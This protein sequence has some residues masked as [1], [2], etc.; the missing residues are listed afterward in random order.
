M[1]GVAPYLPD[2]MDSHAFNALCGMANEHEMAQQAKVTE[3]NQVEAQQTNQA[4]P[5][6]LSVDS[7][8]NAPVASGHSAARQSFD[9]SRSFNRRGIGEDGVRRTN[10]ARDID[11]N[12]NASSIQEDEKAA[13][14]TRRMDTYRSNSDDT[15]MDEDEEEDYLVMDANDNDN[16]GDASDS[17]AGSSTPKDAGTRYELR[18]ENSRHSPNRFTPSDWSTK[19]LKKGVSRLYKNVNDRVKKKYMLTSC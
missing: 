17:A 5:S 14:Y 6:C 2:H 3:E 9:S 19:G 10:T 13:R 1:Q 18:I 12:F 15:D 11:L 8:F 7:H 16:E 4:I